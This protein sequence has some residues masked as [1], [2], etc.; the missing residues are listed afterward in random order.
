DIGFLHAGEN[1]DR[2]RYFGC[3][4][5]FA[6]PAEGIANAVHEIKIAALVLPQQV[7]RA[8]PGI[9]L[10]KDITENLLFRFFLLRIA[11]KAAGR[12][13]G[14][15]GNAA[16]RFAR[17]AHI[18]ANAEAIG[19]THRLLL[20]D[21][22][23]HQLD[24]ELRLRPA[25][26]A[27]NRAFRAVEIHE[28]DIAFR[29]AIKFEDMGNTETLLERLPDFRPQAISHHHAQLVFALLG[30]LFGVEQIAAQLEY[31]LEE[32]RLVLVHITPD[33]RRGKLAAQYHRTANRERHTDGADTTCRV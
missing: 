21:V 29:R 2:F 20:L 32:R 3:G 17:L 12:L 33:L 25:R 9:T 15:I 22:E 26:N 27:A 10:F 30:V 24:I 31:L 23:L 4:D 8:E 11:V 1:R 6:L 18:C 13:I 7:A 19:A 14:I 16:K 28:G 5:I